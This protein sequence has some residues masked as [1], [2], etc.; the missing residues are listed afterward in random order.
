MFNKFQ[1]FQKYGFVWKETLKM[2]IGVRRVFLHLKK[3][4]IYFIYFYYLQNKIEKVKE[5]L[6]RG[7]SYYCWLNLTELLTYFHIVYATFFLFDLFSILLLYLWQQQII[8]TKQTNLRDRKSKKKKLCIFAP[9]LFVSKTNKNMTL[10]GFENYWELKELAKY[11]EGSLEDS[12]GK[13]GCS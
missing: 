11:W 8:N 13:Y 5:I 7:R 1:T 3:F 4:S 6:W 9:K 12:R 2:D 10:C